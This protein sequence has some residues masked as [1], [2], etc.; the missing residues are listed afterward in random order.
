MSFEKAKAQ[1]AFLKIGEYGPPGSGKTFT[2]LLVAE[3]LA[4]RTGKR[5]AFVDTERGTD[6][7]AM[8]VAE[9]KV[10]PEAFDFDALY[11]RSLAEVLATVKALDTDKYGVLVIDS[12]SH[13]WDAA[14]EAYSGRKVGKDQDKIPMQAWG[15]IKKPYKERRTRH[16]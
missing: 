13:I 16:R 12:I 5:V 9:R 15:P 3:G 10:H 7:Y 14:M 4:K 8:A 6:F 2:A 11:S 1:Q